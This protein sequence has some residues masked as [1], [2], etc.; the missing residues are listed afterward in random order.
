[1][2]AKTPRPLP[3]WLAVLC[4][5]LL[6]VAAGFAHRVLDHRAEVRRTPVAHAAACLE[7]LVHLRRERPAEAAE[8]LRRHRDEH[9]AAGAAP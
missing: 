6:G 2:D 1:M 5:L 8:V 3:S 4:F 9:A 7:A